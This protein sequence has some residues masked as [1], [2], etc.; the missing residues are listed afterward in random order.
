MYFHS[1]AIF[2]P[3][4][5]TWPFILKTRIPFIQEFGWNRASGSVE[6]VENVK[7]LQWRQQKRRWQQR[8]MDWSFDQESS[9]EPSAKSHTERL[10]S[11]RL[12]EAEI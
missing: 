11:A 2:F 6:E 5:R 4:K 3:W 9:F 7:I 10:V 1:F 12:V 8:T